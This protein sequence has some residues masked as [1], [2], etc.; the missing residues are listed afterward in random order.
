MLRLEIEQMKGALDTLAREETVL[1]VDRR[2]D[3][4]DRRFNDFE[5][6]VVGRCRTEAERRRPVQ[7]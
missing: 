4:F 3:D 5:D 1:S 6:H 2:W 7:R